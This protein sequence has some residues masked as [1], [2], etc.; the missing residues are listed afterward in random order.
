MLVIRALIITSACVFMVS[1]GSIPKGIREFHLQSNATRKTYHKVVVR[2]FTGRGD[3]ALRSRCADAFADALRTARPKAS[4]VRNAIPDAETLL[5]NGK[6]TH[7]NK[8]KWTT[9]NMGY[10]ISASDGGTGE[11]IV[12]ATYKWR[13]PS[14]QQTQNQL[15]AGLNFGIRSDA[16]LIAPR[17][18]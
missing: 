17:V 11:T 5:I 15:D 7:Y 14:L 3:P 18:Y 10:S 1:C 6:I 13:S 2:D 9:F 16:R 8:R 12:S 4:V